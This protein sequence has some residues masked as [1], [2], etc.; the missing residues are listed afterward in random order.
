MLT[1]TAVSDSETL[2]DEDEVPVADIDPAVTVAVAVAV[3][4]PVAVP[5]ALVL[6]VVDGVVAVPVADSLT[7]PVSSPL[8]A[9]RRN[10]PAARV[11][12]NCV[13][14]IDLPSCWGPPPRRPE[15]RERCKRRGSRPTG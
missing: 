4:V 13:L 10:A 14:T 12:R 11:A 9:A 5:V 6:A 3:A 8:Q 7:L 15:R 2:V 1:L